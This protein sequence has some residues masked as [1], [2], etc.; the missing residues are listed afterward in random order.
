MNEMIIFNYLVLAILILRRIILLMDLNLLKVFAAIYR[1]QNLSRAAEQLFLTQPAVSHSLRKL[2]EQFNDPLFQRDGR[3][4]RPTPLAQRIAPQLQQNLA[5]LENLTNPAAVFDPATSQR[6]FV[7][8]ARDAMESLLLVQ[9]FNAVNQQAPQVTLSSVKLDRAN[10]ARDLARGR[11]DFALDV[12]VPVGAE[13]CYTPTVHD[14]F[15][16]VAAH[17]HSYAQTPTL[18]RYLQSKHVAV[19]ARPSGPTIVDFAMQK[20]GHQR[21]I[22]LRCQHYHAACAVAADAGLLVT[23]PRG[24]AEQMHNPE[25]TR[26]LP[27]PLTMEPIE[28]HLYWH[29]NYDA[30]PG[31]Q[32]L[33]QLASELMRQNA[34]S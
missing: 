19:S 22:G 1:E 34:A 8:G 21:D 33:H 4:M 27:P 24:F 25:K 12:P 17:Q 23:L 5:A 30:D 14:Q 18:K 2:R 10:M 15:C 31:N 32:W 7:I 6:H 9:L 29:R 20:L 11:L 16:V 26:I 28:L 3:T 13:I